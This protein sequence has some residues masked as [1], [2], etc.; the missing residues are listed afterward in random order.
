[1]TSNSN[2]KRLWEY[3]NEKFTTKI[4]V[5]YVTDSTYMRKLAD[6]DRVREEKRAK[7]ERIKSAYP[8]EWKQYYTN[9]AL[10]KTF[11]KCLHVVA[12][13]FRRF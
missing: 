1:M 7:M 6:L 10:W 5:K 4:N 11:C 2:A 9:Y 3:D 8:K 13:S 12:I